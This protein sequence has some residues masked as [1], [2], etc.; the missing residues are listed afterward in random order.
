MN[1]KNCGRQNPSGSLYCQDCGHRLGDWVPPERPGKMPTP[2]TGIARQREGAPA[3]PA[4]QVCPRCGSANATHMRFCNNCG[5]QLGGAAQGAPAAAPAPQPAPA[6]AFSPPQPQPAFSPPAF[7]PPVSSSAGSVCWRCRAAGDAGAEFCKF[8][9]ARYADDPSRAAPAAPFAGSTV[10]SAIAAYA[11]AAPPAH[12]G[13]A[14]M[15]QMGAAPMGMASPIAMHG[16]PA[17][18]MSPAPAQ[19]MPVSAPRAREATQLESQSPRV[20]GAPRALLVAILKDGS[21]GRVYP[22]HDEQTDIG[23]SEGHLVLADDPYL[24]ARHARVLVRG[25]QLVLR[26]LDSVNGIYV[27]LREPV[28][29]HDADMILLGQQVVRFEVLAESELPLGPATHRGV[30]VFGTPE[31]PRIARLVQYT[32]EGVGRDV[33]YLYRDETVIGREQGDIVCTDDPFMSRRHAAITVDRSQ[34]RFVLRDLG[35]S[36]GTAIRIRGER[37]LRPGDQFRIGRHLFRYDRPGDPAGGRAQ[38]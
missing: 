33:H 36:N 11:A 30:L 38:A 16:A 32:T 19:P 26:D 17:P 20:E 25:D 9:G 22:I 13:A 4:M 15:P 34:R 21:D 31:V 27:R 8:C 2:P 12:N 37:A 29:L 7:S 1:C 24:S 3:A 35:S 28:D 23:R 5:F 14:P 10:G 6:Y 18:V